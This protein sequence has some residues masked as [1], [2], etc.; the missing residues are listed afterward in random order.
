MNK[1][2]VYKDQKLPKNRNGSNWAQIRLKMGVQN[3][4]LLLGV[5]I[6]RI[7]SVFADF[8]KTE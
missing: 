1:L 2:L 6:S 3:A 8:D 7:G 5:S 4:T